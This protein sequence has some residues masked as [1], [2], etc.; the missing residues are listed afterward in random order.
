MEPAGNTTRPRRSGLPLLVGVVV[1]LGAAPMAAIAT[2]DLVV[3]P[4]PPKEWAAAVF[5]GTVVRV[6]PAPGRAG[7]ARWAVVATA[8][9]ERRM[10]MEVHDGLPKPGWSVVKRAGET[11]FDFATEDAPGRWQSSTPEPEPGDGLGAG[12][13]LC[14]GWFVALLLPLAGLAALVSRRPAPTPGS[15]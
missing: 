6:E 12:C 7:K 1:A 13:A 10:P 5:S 8:E 15:S 14:A 11:S 4:Y 9:G 2:F 3:A